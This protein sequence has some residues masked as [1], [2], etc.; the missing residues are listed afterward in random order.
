MAVVSMV[1]AGIRRMP[2]TPRP[3]CTACGSPLLDGTAVIAGKLRRDALICSACDRL[4]V[5]CTC[6]RSLA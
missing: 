2:A 3:A 6:E 5:C 1:R 4:G